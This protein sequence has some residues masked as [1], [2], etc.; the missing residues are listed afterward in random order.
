MSGQPVRTSESDPICLDFLSDQT[1]LAAVGMT[2]APGKKDRSVDDGLWFRDLTSDLE[3]LR[4]FYGV[5][6]L[7]CLLEPPEFRMLGIPD[8]EAEVARL[9]LQLLHFPIRD[10][11]VPTDIPATS[12][13]VGHILRAADGGGTIAIH[14]RGGLGRSGLI[15][16][17]CLVTRDFTAAAAIAAVR[18]ARSGTIETREQEGFVDRFAA[19]LAST[20]RK[21]G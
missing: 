10:G 5:A 9:G 3:R 13:L 18:L 17:C 2:F 7:V 19:Y 6:T 14:C 8:Y 4:D 16:A 12:D 21:R 20:R 15:A 11:G 1:G